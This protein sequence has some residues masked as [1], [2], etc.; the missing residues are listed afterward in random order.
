MEN[1]QKMEVNQFSSL[2]KMRIKI[3][4][5]YSIIINYQYLIFLEFYGGK[6]ELYRLSQIFIFQNTENATQKKSLQYSE[7]W[8]HF[9]VS[10]FGHHHNSGSLCYISSKRQFSVP[11]DTASEIEKYLCTLSIKS[12]LKCQIKLLR[13]LYQV[14]SLHL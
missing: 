5:G 3:C 13:L 4:L 12:H 14:T 2:K 10:S 8:S 11:W 7:I 1:T 6:P 9:Y